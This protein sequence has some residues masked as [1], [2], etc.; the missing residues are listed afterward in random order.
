MDIVDNLFSTG[1]DSHSA[2]AILK[3]AEQALLQHWRLH[4]G[5]NS[6]MFVSAAPPQLGSMDLDEWKHLSHMRCLGHHLSSN[7]SIAIDFH[8]TVKAV[9][10]AYWRNAGES[11]RVAG[12][13]VQARFM[14]SSLKSIAGE[15]PWAIK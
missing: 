12:D 3:D 1:F 2:M 11:L 10:G 15:N 6:K 7:S 13:K 14:N 8:A 4:L 5:A 9:W